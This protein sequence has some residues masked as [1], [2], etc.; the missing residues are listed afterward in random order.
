MVHHSQRETNEKEYGI[1]MAEY[2]QIKG[3]KSYGRFFIFFPLCTDVSV[4]LLQSVEHSVIQQYFVVSIATFISLLEI[5]A[6]ANY[7]EFLDRL[8]LTVVTI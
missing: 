6:D 4:C 8:R 7:A 1:I 5:I 2:K 3:N